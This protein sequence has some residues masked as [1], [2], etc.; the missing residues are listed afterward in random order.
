VD[1]VPFSFETLDVHGKGLAFGAYALDLAKS[2]PESHSALALELSRT[3][4][5]ISS[6]IAAGA[7]VWVR[8]QKKELFYAARASCYRCASMLALGKELG[9]VNES[10]ME[11]VSEQVETITKMLTKLAQ[12]VDKD[13]SKSTAATAES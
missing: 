11:G 4:I 6:D 2:F 10:D 13:R 8:N 7:S 3:A 9:H 1:P 5:S 12:S